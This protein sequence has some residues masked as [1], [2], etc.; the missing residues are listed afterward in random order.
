MASADLRLM[1]APRETY[2][3]LT[4]HQGRVEPAAALQRPLLVA[5]VIG[6][7]IALA[8]TRR[9][10]LALVAST[11]LSWSYIVV[12][13]LLIAVPLL[14]RRARRTVGLPRAIDLYFAGHAPWSLFV[15]F[16][17]A[18]GPAAGGRRLWPLE[19]AA[20]IALVLTLR[21]LSA[22]FEVVLAMDGRSARRMT[23]LQQAITWSLF[24]ALNW[25]ASAFTPRL[26]ELKALW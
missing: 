2:A 13:Q 26:Y 18:W 12:L 7:S 19:V 9:I 14:A 15:L 3:A 21:I 17:A 6:V 10:S 4:Q 25:W 11:T 5:L 23:I 1:A 24:I 20:V 22:F 16:A 8:A